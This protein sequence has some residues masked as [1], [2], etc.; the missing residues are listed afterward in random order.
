MKIQVNNKVTY[1]KV[2]LGTFKNFKPKHIRE[3]GTVI[4][5][6]KDHLGVV[7]IVRWE[8]R[9]ETPLHIENLK[10]IS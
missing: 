4:R 7:A 1:S 6:K 10:R 8:D 9:S 5:I 3:I 2:Y